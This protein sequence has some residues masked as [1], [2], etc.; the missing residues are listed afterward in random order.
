MIG[1]FGIRKIQRVL[2][3]DYPRINF[4]EACILKLEVVF[5]IFVNSFYVKKMSILGFLHKNEGQKSTIVKD[6]HAIRHICDSER[7]H[8]YQASATKS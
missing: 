4:G 1:E 5:T 6:Y 3:S 2:I 7:S 8:G